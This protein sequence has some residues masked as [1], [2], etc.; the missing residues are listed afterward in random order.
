MNFFTCYVFLPPPLLLSCLVSVLFPFP[1]L[2]LVSFTCM[3][4]CD[5]IFL[6]PISYQVPYMVRYRT[7]F[8]FRQNCI[9]CLNRFLDIS[10]KRK[11]NQRQSRPKMMKLGTCLQLI[12]TGMYECQRCI[13]KVTWLTLEWLYL[14][15]ARVKTRSI[16]LK[17]NR[18]VLNTREYTCTVTKWI[19]KT[20]MNFYKA[21]G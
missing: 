21:R 6:A 20:R 10:G 13:S 2:C 12:N 18:N 15:N 19:A 17:Y 9:S 7:C 3:F 1:S 4:S 16:L 5:S 8:F 14:H 11:C